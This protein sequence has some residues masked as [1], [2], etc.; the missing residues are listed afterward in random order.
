MPMRMQQISLY[1][2]KRA[3]IS[4]AEVP[5][6]CDWNRDDTEGFNYGKPNNDGDQL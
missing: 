1:L 4:V 2:S 3:A 6:R 5:R